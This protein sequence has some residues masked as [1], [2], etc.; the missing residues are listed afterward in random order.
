MNLQSRLTTQFYHKFMI[1]VVSNYSRYNLSTKA[2][3]ISNDS[4]F[5]M[6][7]SQSGSV[8]LDYCDIVGAWSAFPEKSE[9]HRRSIETG[10]TA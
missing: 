6:E 10:V 2:S 4:L 8:L 3:H 7:N 5:E 1:S 9:A